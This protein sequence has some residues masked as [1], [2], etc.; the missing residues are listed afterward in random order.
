MLHDA[1]TLKYNFPEIAFELECDQVRV[2]LVDKLGL[3]ACVNVTDK[4]AIATV[5]L[6][7]GFELL[8][9]PAMPGFHGYKNWFKW[10][11]LV[12]P[13][14]GEEIRM[15]QVR[16]TVELITYDPETDSYPG[17]ISLGLDAPNMERLLS[18]TLDKIQKLCG[19][20]LVA[21]PVVKIN[22]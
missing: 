15:S 22:N 3:Q 9:R 5:V 12:N 11:Q 21:L 2:E 16:C 18:K 4:S 1:E 7:D 14:S 19:L 6:N 10:S 13:K 20:R 8:I 17:V